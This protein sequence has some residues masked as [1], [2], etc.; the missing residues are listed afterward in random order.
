MSLSKSEAMGVLVMLAGINT[1]EGIEGAG[2]VGKSILG[3]L[4]DMDDEMYKKTIATFLESAIAGLEFSKE[5][6]SKYKVQ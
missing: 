6:I 4:V 5:A 2:Q 3:Q 1:P